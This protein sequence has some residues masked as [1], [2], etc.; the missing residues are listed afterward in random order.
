[1]H[2]CIVHHLVV[3]LAKLIWCSGRRDARWVLNVQLLRCWLNS[4][5]P[6]FL[7]RDLLLNRSLRYILYKL[8][9]AWRALRSHN[10]CWLLGLGL[11]FEHWWLTLT[12]YLDMVVIVNMDWWCTAAHISIELLFLGFL[13]HLDGIYQALRVLKL[14]L[15]YRYSVPRVKIHLLLLYACLRDRVLLIIYLER[16][17]MLRT[18]LGVN[19]VLW[20][21]GHPLEMLNLTKIW[22]MYHII[23]GLL[24]HKIPLSLSFN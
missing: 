5:L 9:I 8:G 19:H 3:E 13:Q 4:G 21:H 2:R 10:A 22:L 23:E 18:I 24:G 20:V 6:K 11:D 17:W 12:D 15:T 14:L 16:I 7:D 1:M